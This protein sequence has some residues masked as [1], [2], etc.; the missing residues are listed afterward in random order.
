V[1]EN[2]AIRDLLAEGAARHGQSF[3]EAAKGSDTDFTFAALDRANAALRTALITLHIAA[4]EAGDT[5]LDQ[6]ILRF[7]VKSADMRRLDLPPMPAS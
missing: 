5:A 1:W 6:A 4:E 7:Y 3:A 2:A